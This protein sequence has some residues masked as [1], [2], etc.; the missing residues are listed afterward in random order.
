[1]IVR[2][3]FCSLALVLINPA[4]DRIYAEIARLWAWPS[5]GA[6]IAPSSA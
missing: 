6:Q 5:I 1:V 3:S 2:P 4:V